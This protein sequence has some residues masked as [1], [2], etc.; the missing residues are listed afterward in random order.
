MTIT[1]LTLRL[2]SRDG[3]VVSYTPRTEPVAWAMPSAPPVSR[4]AYAAAHVVPTV[5]SDTSPLGAASLDWDST[6]AFRHRL[7][8]RGLGVAEAMDTAQ[9]GMG[10][11]WENTRELIARSGREAAAAGGRIACG[12]G[13]DQLDLAAVPAGEVGLRVVVDA[14]KEQI[15]VV[16]DAGATG[17]L[18]ASRALAAVAR[19]ADDYLQVYREV[20]A[21]AQSPVILH[22]LGEMFDPAL[23]GYWGTTDIDTAMDTVAGLIRDHAAG[24]DGIKM[25]LLDAQAELRL[26][27]QLP[28]G[29]RMYT[30]DDFN[31]PDLVVGDAQGYSDALLGVF[32]AI[33]P[34]A[35]AALQELDRHNAGEA[36]RILES[37]RDLGRHLFAG[38]T[39]Y[40]KTGIAFLAWLNG[41]Q[42]GF[43]MVGG[44]HSGRSVPHLAQAYRLAD[45]AGLILDPDGATDR[46]RRFLEV[47]G[48]EATA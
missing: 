17:I 7:W 26:R 6:L 39:M 47:H 19:H 28:S 40:Y 11:S 4:V 23:R 20:I 34:A 8:E 38:P 33:F 13:T 25:S 32:A 48:W 31:Y 12:A 3:S 9:R 44:L 18:M 41:F 43:S 27:A 22:W 24:I 15:D 42:P 5:T 30:G 1:T 36:H 35:S 14:Y 29:V 10:L 37:T 21:Y 46:L 45:E 16:R 2:P